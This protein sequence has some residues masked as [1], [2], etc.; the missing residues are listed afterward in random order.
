MYKKKNLPKKLLGLRKMC[1][2]DR[3]K[4]CNLEPIET[5]R[6][7]ADFTLTYTIIN[8]TIYVNLHNCVSISCSTRRGNKYKLTKYHAKLDIRNFFAY[9]TVNV[10]NILHNDIAGF[11]TAYGLIAIFEIT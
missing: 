1:C 8:D 6:L 10:W 2:Q 3:L 7:H 4:L 5:R 11:E 9:R